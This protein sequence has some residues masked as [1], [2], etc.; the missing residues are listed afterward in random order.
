[1]EELLSIVDG[2]ERILGEQEGKKKR[3][4]KEIENLKDELD[5]QKE[6][7]SSFQE[8]TKSDTTKTIKTYSDL[9]IKLNDDYKNQIQLLREQKLEILKEIEE[10]ESFHK[11][12]M[13][14]IEKE[15]NQAETA[16]SNANRA[17]SDMKGK[18]QAL[19]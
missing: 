9:A 18:L 17:L 2:V 13:S 11:K 10:T 4:L 3:L 5:M 19:G 15:Q 12:K 6:T 16:L 14:A 7:Y 1:M 8:K